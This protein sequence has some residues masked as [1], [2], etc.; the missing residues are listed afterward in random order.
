MLAIFDDGRLSWLI[1]KGISNYSKHTTRCP[2]KE[3]AAPVCVLAWRGAKSPSSLT[4]NVK[5]QISSNTHSL[6]VSIYKGF[7]TTRW[8]RETLLLLMNPDKWKKPA[9][10][11]DLHFR[12]K[13][14]LKGINCAVKC[15]YDI[16][17]VRLTIV[18]NN[19]EKAY[20]CEGSL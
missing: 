15:N 13:I 4:I 6:S 16:I 18:K 14:P 12:I 20:S 9:A 3:L 11:D 2:Q 7:I 1:L 5:H 10:G 19:E 17:R 8:E